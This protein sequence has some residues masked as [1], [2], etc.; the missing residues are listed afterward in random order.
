MRILKKI[1]NWFRKSDIGKQSQA[2]KARQHDLEIL[3][4]K[5]PEEI[6]CWAKL[7][8]KRGRCMRKTWGVRC[9][10]HGE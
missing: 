4:S 10:Q 5:Q 6:Y 8:S 9:W 1:L 3:Q 7:S 2:E